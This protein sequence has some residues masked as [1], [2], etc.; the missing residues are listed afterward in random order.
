MK[1]AIIIG[2]IIM[3]RRERREYFNISLLALTKFSIKIEGIFIRSDL[4]STVGL[5]LNS[6]D[7]RNVEIW[8]IRR[9]CNLL[10]A[11]TVINSTQVDYESVFFQRVIK[12]L[13]ALSSYESAK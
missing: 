8:L 2:K 12:R 9:F 13:S 7:T 3:G 6:I 1:K 11:F 4:F 5:T 10:L